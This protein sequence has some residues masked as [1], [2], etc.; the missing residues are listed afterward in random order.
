MLVDNF[1]VF[2][3]HM[4]FDSAD[5]FY[6][7]QVITRPKDGHKIHG[8]N[9]NRTLKFYTIRSIEEF[10]RVESEVKALCKEFNARAYI[11]YT[12]RLFSQ[13]AK[14]MLPKVTEQYIDGNFQGM[15][16]AFQDSCGKSVV[17]KYKTYLVDIDSKD[18]VLIQS[19]ISTINK[20]FPLGV[21]KIITMF[22]TSSGYHLITKPFHVEKFNEF[23]PQIDVHL[24]NP[25][26]LYRYDE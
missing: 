14:L 1:S 25:T 10:D 23:Y 6:F 16:G 7:L 13:V 15:K 3:T 8:N 12:K 18:Q 11:H 5:E 24:N 21:D 19:I 2:R 9:I 20:C 26:L 4:Q 22:E 17:K